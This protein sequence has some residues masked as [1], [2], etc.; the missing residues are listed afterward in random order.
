MTVDVKNQAN[1]L[2]T[3]VVPMAGFDKAFDGPPIDPKVLEE[4]QKKL[5]A[6]LQKRAEDERKKLEAAKPRMRLAARPRLRRPPRLQRLRLSSKREIARQPP[7]IAAPAALSAP[8][9]RPG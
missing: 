5:Q 4:Q 6:E 3:F 1:N 7:R 2:V 9:N 8:G